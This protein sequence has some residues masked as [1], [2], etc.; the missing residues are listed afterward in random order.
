L[1]KICIGEVSKIK[2]VQHTFENQNHHLISTS[3]GE[4]TVSNVATASVIAKTGANAEALTKIAFHREQHLVIELIEKLN[5]SV[6]IVEKNGE[7]TRS[8]NWSKFAI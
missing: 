4:S 5:G 6:L 2:Y 7:T 1:K 3:T 8:Q